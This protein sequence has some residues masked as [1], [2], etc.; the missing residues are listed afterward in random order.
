MGKSVHKLYTVNLKG[1][2]SAV[3][4]SVE[5]LDSVIDALTSQYPKTKIITTVHDLT[6]TKAPLKM[7]DVTFPKETK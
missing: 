3:D 5:M 7:V 6:D 1:A 4:G 2:E